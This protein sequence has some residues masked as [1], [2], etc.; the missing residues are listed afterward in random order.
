[1]NSVWLINYGYGAER[2]FSS[3]E[4]AY[5]AA[6]DQLINWGY[7]PEDEDEASFFTDLKESYDNPD[8]KGFFVDEVLW[9]WEVPLD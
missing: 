5:D 9:C 4:D 7:N 1:M 8:Y 6:Y 3:I 2:A